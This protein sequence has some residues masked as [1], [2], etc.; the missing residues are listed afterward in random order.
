MLW[1]R[2]AVESRSL[3]DTVAERDDRWRLRRMQRPGCQRRRE[4][5]SVASAKNAP[6]MRLRHP[7]AR[8]SQ[9]RP[10]VKT[11]RDVQQ[12]LRHLLQPSQSAFALLHAEEYPRR[13]AG[14]GQSGGEFWRQT[15][16]A[17]GI[18]QEQRAGDQPTPAEHP[19]H[20]GRATSLPLKLKSLEDAKDLC[21]ATCFYVRFLFLCDVC[22]QIYI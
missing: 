15:G 14:A 13:A 5:R 16:S 21:A 11:Y 18:R 22:L 20:H 12:R 17:A 3:F 2:I 6:R 19:V 7:H 8:K 9:P 1:S 10:G 4:A